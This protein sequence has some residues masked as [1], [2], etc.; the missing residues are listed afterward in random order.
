MSDSKENSSTHS[1]S[2]ESKKNFVDT[3]IQHFKKFDFSQL[4]PSFSSPNEHRQKKLQNL[5]KDFSYLM[6]IVSFSSRYLSAVRHIAEILGMTKIYTGE[7]LFEDATYEGNAIEAFI[8]YT[9][10]INESSEKFV[11]QSG[12]LYCVTGLDDTVRYTTSLRDISCCK[13]VRKVSSEKN[14]DVVIALLEE[15]R[16]DIE[17]HDLERRLRQIDEM[18]LTSNYILIPL[19]KKYDDISMLTGVDKQVYEYATEKTGKKL[20]LDTR[21]VCEIA[22]ESENSEFLYPMNGIECLPESELSSFFTESEYVPVY[23]CEYDVCLL[24]CESD[25]NESDDNESDHDE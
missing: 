15:I 17:E 12:E 3:L 6:T 22:N 5:R 20:V 25:D 19:S 24:F 8:A 18:D 10:C 21:N 1:Y 7:S 11:Y 2:S 16:D 4:P 23:A 14:L 13:S 9:E